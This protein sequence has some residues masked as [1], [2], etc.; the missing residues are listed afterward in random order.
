MADRKQVTQID[1]E[2]A[3]DKVRYGRENRSLSGDDRDLRE[4][5][6]HEAGHAI[7]V[8]E[9]PHVEPL[10]K[11]TIIP[12]GRSL[13]AT[14]ILPE[15][16]RRNYL[17][18]QLL[19]QIEVCFGGRIAE[20]LCLGDVSSGAVQD[21]E[22]ATT[23]ARRM[24]CDFGMSRL[25]PVHY[26][27]REQP[28]FLA[29]EFPVPREYSEATAERIDVEVSRII[30][31]AYANAKRRLEHHIDDLH[32]LAAALI[33]RETLTAEEVEDLLA[34]PNMEDRSSSPATPT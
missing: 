4:T 8:R 7:L 33:E 5:A 32:R 14:M 21:I 29:G 3:R 13:G 12:R 19:G 20:E 18:S 31:E 25:G 9:T 17:Q 2:E 27:E 23:I 28:S 11:V 24:V 30:D 1:L 10:H 16:D 34:G 26:S 6:Y 15:K 22:Q